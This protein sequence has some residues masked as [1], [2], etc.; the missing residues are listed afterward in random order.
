[1]EQAQ[2]AKSSQEL[3][4]WKALSVKQR[5]YMEKFGITPS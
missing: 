4:K 3:K 2:L 5:Y 1:M